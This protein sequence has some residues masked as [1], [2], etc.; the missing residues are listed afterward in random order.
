MLV[1]A[2]WLGSSLWP[3][4][5]SIYEQQAWVSITPHTFT[6]YIYNGLPRVSVSGPVYT[7]LCEIAILLPKGRFLVLIVLLSADLGYVAFLSS[8][9]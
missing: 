5:M 1:Y 8:T 3:R 6:A 7:P 9:L 2:N 4:P